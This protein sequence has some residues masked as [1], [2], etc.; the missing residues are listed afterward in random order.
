LQHHLLAC[1]QRDVT[2]RNTNIFIVTAVVTPNIIRLSLFDIL[3]ELQD[4]TLTLKDSINTI[5]YYYY[6]ESVLVKVL[7]Y[8]IEGREFDI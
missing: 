8:K 4:I 7:S 3:E 1:V 5:I 2:L 6:R